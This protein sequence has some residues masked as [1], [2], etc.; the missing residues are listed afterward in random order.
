MTQVLSRSHLN[1]LGLVLDDGLLVLQRGFQ[2]LVPLQQRLPEF[3][4]QLEICKRSKKGKVSN[5]RV[6]QMTA[7]KFTRSLNKVVEKDAVLATVLHRK[8]WTRNRSIQPSSKPADGMTVS[9]A[10]VSMH[11][12]SVS[13]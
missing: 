8:I 4:R 12:L 13:R 10:A 1:F 6:S 3:R 11:A 7:N 9:A 2:L 5:Q